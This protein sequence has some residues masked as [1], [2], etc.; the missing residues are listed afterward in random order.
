MLVVRAAM[1][2]RDF[3]LVL[4]AKHGFVPYDVATQAATPGCN[5]GTDRSSL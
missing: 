1:R 4:T 5:A 2:K 3:F